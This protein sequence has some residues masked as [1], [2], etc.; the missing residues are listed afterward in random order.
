MA[1]GALRLVLALTTA[2][3][4]AMLAPAALAADRVAVLILP[5]PGTDQALADNL[6]EIAIARIA[7]R[8]NLDTVGTI[9]LR[10]RLQMDGQRPT[11][12]CLDNI[13]CLGRVAVALGVARVVGGSV[14][15]YSASRFLI[16]M[17]LTE[18]GSG[19]VAGRFF[20]LVQGGVDQLIAVAQ[21]GTD[22]LFRRQEEPGRIRV[23]SDPPQARVTIDD[24]FVGNT[25]VISGTLVPGPH[26]VRVEKEKRFPWQETVMLKSAT[27][28]EIKLTPENLPGRRTWPTYLA[29]GGLGATAVSAGLASVLGAMSQEEPDTTVRLRVQQDLQRR[30]KL[31]TTA[32]V[33]FAGAAVLAAVSTVV[34]YVYR[35]DVFGE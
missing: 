6:T 10:R 13:A 23:E 30:Q 35:R 25:P 14:R 33:I 9:E 16:N 8:Q 1:A 20:R 19:R 18:V 21:E 27:E 32:N 7:E 12:A 3:V 34:L 29:F 5:E 11:V 2:V 22:D 28:L 31:A 24:L 26:R 17:T 4:L 15:A